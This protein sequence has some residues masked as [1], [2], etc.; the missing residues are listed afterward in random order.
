MKVK[1]RVA[2]LMATVLTMSIPA[3]ANASPLTSK[4][5]LLW[6]GQV[7]DFE[8]RPAAA[9]ITAVLAPPSGIVPMRDE[10]ASWRAACG[11]HSAVHRY[12]RV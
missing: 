5:P 3:I 6:K 2:T 11:L 10:A 4:V 9:T 12:R 7:V 1:L 8:G